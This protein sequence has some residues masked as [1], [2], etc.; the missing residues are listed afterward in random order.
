MKKVSFMILTLLIGFSSISFAASND[1]VDN[2][3]LVSFRH[4]FQNATNVSW[5]QTST[6]YKATF[7]LDGQTIYAYYGKN[8]A[9]LVAVTRFIL[10]S[11]LPLN[12]Q[13]ELR[14]KLKDGWIADLFEVVS[15]GETYYYATIENSAA[16]TIFKSSGFSNWSQISKAAK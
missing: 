6:C 5:A 14:S 9:G 7:E 8:E 15:G 11:Q 10:S 16:K 3:T 1:K 2:A 4:D 13:Q 12:L